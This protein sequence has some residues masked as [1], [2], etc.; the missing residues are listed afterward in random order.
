MG[1]FK[2]HM[3]ASG[4][5]GNATIVQAGRTCVLIDAGISARR[6]SA[7]MK[8][9]GFNYADISGV[10]VTHE[11]IDHINGLPVFS[12]QSE[13]NVY[14]NEKTWMAASKLSTVENRFRRLLPEEGITIGDITVKSFRLS[15]DAA[16]PV[17]FNLFAK[18]CK[19]SVATDLGCPTA[20]VKKALYG[21]DTIIIEAN[22]DLEMLDNGSYPWHLKRRVRSSRGH[23][24]NTDAGF[25]LSEVMTA[26]RTQVFLAHLSEEN[27]TPDIARKTV[28]NILSDKGML[29]TA[30]IYVAGRDGLVSSN[31]CGGG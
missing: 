20:E 2:V 17:G 8:K 15:H 11:H 28:E 1:E 5:K 19:C 25:I 21:S 26:R 22:H 23:L 4:S 30:E 6:I 18:G 3:I 10:F 13:I 29:E 9:A 24:S 7:G 31:K 16:S 12:K 14:A 27:N